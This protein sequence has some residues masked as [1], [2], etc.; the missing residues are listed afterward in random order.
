MRF[1]RRRVG[2]LSSC[3]ETVALPISSDISDTNEIISFVILY[4]GSFNVITRFCG[5]FLLY[6]DYSTRALWVSRGNIAAHKRAQ[7]VPLKLYAISKLVPASDSAHNIS[8]P[9][10]Q[11]SRIRDLKPLAKISEKGYSIIKAEK[12]EH[13]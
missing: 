1:L 10:K 9:L 3:D 12:G 7:A 2:F 11:F 6:T 4:G 13:A 8:T 5:G